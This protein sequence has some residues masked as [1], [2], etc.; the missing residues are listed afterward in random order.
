[1]KTSNKLDAAKQQVDNTLL[2]LKNDPEPDG[3]NRKDGIAEVSLLQA[4]LMNIQNP[5]NFVNNFLKCVTM[6]LNEMKHRN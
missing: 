3:D 1:M 4:A 5:L 6:P 2:D